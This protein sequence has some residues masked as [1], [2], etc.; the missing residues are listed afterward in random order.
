MLPDAVFKRYRRLNTSKSK[1]RVR[2]PAFGLRFGG[3][4]SP[5]DGCSRLL[6]G[7]FFSFT[8]MLFG[9]LFSVLRKLRNIAGQ[10]GFHLTL[11]I[12]CTE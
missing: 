4:I 10:A 2:T 11:A 9:E 3:F 7:R 12:P 1:V 5:S 8:R 6:G